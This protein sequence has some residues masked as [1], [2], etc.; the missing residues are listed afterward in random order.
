MTSTC[1]QANKNVL[2][3]YQRFQLFCSC[4]I[5]W[6]TMCVCVCVCVCV[7]APEHVRVCVSSLHLAELLYSLVFNK[8]IQLYFIL[9]TSQLR[10]LHQ[11]LKILQVTYLKEWVLSG[12]WLGLLEWP[13][14]PGWLL[15]LLQLWLIICRD[16]HT[17][18]HSGILLQQ[19]DATATTHKTLHCL[20]MQTVMFLKHSHEYRCGSERIK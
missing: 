8:C 12:L 17:D 18:V 16:D 19:H 6:Y 2:F 20:L 13:P 7:R 1:D 10:K 3:G 15:I 11:L 14:L 9:L 4:S 5:I